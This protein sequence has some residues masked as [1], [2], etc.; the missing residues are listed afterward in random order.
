MKRL[1]LGVA[2]AAMTSIQVFAADMPVKARPVAADLAYD[3]SGFYIGAGTGGVWYEARRFMP[4]LPLV[5]IPPTLFR[6][7]SSDWIYDGHAGVQRQ[8]GRWVIGLEGAYNGSRGNMRS[9]VSVSPP[10][11]FSNF[12]ATVFITDL[13]TVGPKLGYTWDRLMVYGTGGYAGANIDGRYTCTF[14]GQF[15]FPG[16][17]PCNFPLFGV[18]ADLNLSGT[19]WNNGWFAGLGFDYVVYKGSLGDILLGAEY[20]HFNLDRMQAVTCTPTLCPGVPHQSFL[21]DANGDIARVRLSF[22][23]HGWGIQ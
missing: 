5:G 20:Q 2:V 12:N 10:E 16:R 14:G 17:A 8:W 21:H 6:A 23:T 13:V 7:H 1:A 4:D 11:P 18:L 9:D 15:I 3:W 19:T 22:K